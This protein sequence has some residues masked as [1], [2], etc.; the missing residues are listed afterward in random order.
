[1]IMFFLLERVSGVRGLSLGGAITDLKVNLRRVPREP[2][3][4]HA[5]FS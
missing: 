3:I 1:M 4:V 5:E 2:R